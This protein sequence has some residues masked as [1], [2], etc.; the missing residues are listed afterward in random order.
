MV[1]LVAR[2]DGDANQSRD[3]PEPDEDERC[4]DGPPSTPELVNPLMHQI[5]VANRSVSRPGL[6]RCYQH[7]LGSWPASP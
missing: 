6:W 7:Q 3:S 2:L 4:F 1:P 5:F